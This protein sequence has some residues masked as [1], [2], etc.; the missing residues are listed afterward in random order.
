MPR[1]QQLRYLV[2]IAD[3]LSFSRAAENCHVTQ[4]TLSMQIKELEDRLDMQLVE[5]TRARVILTPIGEAVVDRARNILAEIEDIREIVRR[6]RADV[7]QGPLRIGVVQTVGAYVLS[8]AMP[9]LRKAMPDLRVT[10]REDRLENL[11]QK[12]SDGT[13]DVLLLP[14]ALE[15]PD[16]TSARLMTEPLHLVVPADHPLAKAER[17]APENLC[18]E[19]ILA[20]DRSDQLH[21]QIAALCR[22]VGAIDV[23]DYSGTTLDTLRQMVAIGMGL[24]LLPAL[25]VRSDVLRESVIVARPLVSKAPVRELTM[26]WRKSSPRQAVYRRI[27]DSIAASLAPWE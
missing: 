6:E 27:A 5:R 3:T 26:V 15:H 1:L 12:L 19:T 25:Y 14:N 17:V 8:L 21:S 4:P 7:L 10:V 18:G 2:A 11:P 20:M 9:P 16:Y 13:H 24:A 23:Q 22:E